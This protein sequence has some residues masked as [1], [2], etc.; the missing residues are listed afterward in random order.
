V[1]NVIYITQF[2]DLTVD[3]MLD[4]MYTGNYDDG[5]EDLDEIDQPSGQCKYPYIRAG[6]ENYAKF[7]RLAQAA[8]PDIPMLLSPSP[9]V[10][11]DDNDVNDGGPGF[12]SSENTMATTEESLLFN[13]GVNS[14]ADYYDISPLKGIAN[15]KIRKLLDTAWSAKGFS[16]VISEVFKTTND[17][18]LH[19]MIANA[20]ADHINELIQLDGFAELGFMSD[21]MVHILRI[22]LPHH[23]NKETEL[24]VRIEILKC[25]LDYADNSRKRLLVKQMDQSR[26]SESIISSIEECRALLSRINFCGIS[27]CDARFDCRIERRGPNDAPKYTLYCSKCGVRHEIRGGR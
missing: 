8:V 18:E 23:R 22:A 6:L 19:K 26:R 11:P 24:Y 10:Q 9:S 21:F 16:N 1:E 25:A 27:G 13:V 14:I 5:L 15:E 3:K 20:T 4:F 7:W 17:Q 12:S 2:N